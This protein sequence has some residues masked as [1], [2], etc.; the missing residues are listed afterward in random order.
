M[1]RFLFHAFRVLLVA[2]AAGAAA[3]W[4][5]ARPTAAQRIAVKQSYIDA[6]LKDLVPLLQSVTL[7]PY[8]SPETKAFTGFLVMKIDPGTPAETLGIKEK[9]LV[10]EVNGL[11]ITDAGKGLEAAYSL[12]G[13]SETRVKLQRDG[14]EIEILYQVVPQ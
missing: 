2:L 14:K 11:P 5:G 9:D 6:N 13:V 3:L 4:W 1:K 12:K 7:V 8:I 10:T